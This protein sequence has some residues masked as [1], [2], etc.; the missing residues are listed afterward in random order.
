MLKMRTF[1]GQPGG[2]TNIWKTGPNDEFSMV[3]V[4]EKSIVKNLGSEDVCDWPGHR[5]HFTRV[6]LIKAS[7]P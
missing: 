6:E 7:K 1:P 4:T 3:Q 2:I 5:N